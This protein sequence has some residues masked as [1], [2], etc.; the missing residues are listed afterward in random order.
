MYQGNIFSKCRSISHARS[1]SYT[2]HGKHGRHR[3]EIKKPQYY[4]NNNFPQN[5]VT[6]TI[7]N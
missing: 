4:A 2:R 5:V 1:I 7:K 6:V 3:Q